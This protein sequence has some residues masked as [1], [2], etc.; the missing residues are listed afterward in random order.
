[1]RY[2]RSREIEDIYILPNVSY[3][4]ADPDLELGGQIRAYIMGSSGNAPDQGSEGLRP[5]EADKI[6]LLQKLIS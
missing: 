4:V 6:F 3:S 1:M 5:P 2:N